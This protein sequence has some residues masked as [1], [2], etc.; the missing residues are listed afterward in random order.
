VFQA[1]DAATNDPGFGWNGLVNGKPAPT[2]AYVYEILIDL[3]GGMQHLYKGTV[4]LVR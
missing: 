3:A 4:M 2:G 1:H